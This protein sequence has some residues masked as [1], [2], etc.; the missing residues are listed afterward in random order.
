[1]QQFVVNTEDRK[2]SIK[3]IFLSVEDGDIILNP[4]YQRNYVYDTKRASKII[5]SLLLDIPLPAIFANE[6]QDGSMEI[7]DGVQRITSIIK[8]MRNEYPLLGLE[9]LSE[10][11]NKY[12]KDLSNDEKKFFRQSSLRIIKFKKDCSE[13]LKF[14]IFL[15]LNQGSVKLNNQE[16]RNCMYRGYFNDKLRELSNNKTVKE[17]LSFNENKINRFAIEEFILRGITFLNYNSIVNKKTLNHN[18]NYIMKTYRNS[19]DEVDKMTKDYLEVLS[20]I[21]TIL[22]N[23]A[24]KAEFNEKHK[25]IASYYDSFIIVF[26]KYKKQALIQN[27]DKIK[28]AIKSCFK[29]EEFLNT[30]K[31][32]TT[33]YKNILLRNDIIEKSIKEYI[34]ELDDKRLFSYEDKIKMF[35]NDNICA[36]CKNKIEDINDSNIDHIIPWSKGG[37]TILSNAQLTHEFCNK[38]KSNS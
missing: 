22:G 14:E 12:F 8:F 38:S 32:Q 6:E 1:M 37:K 18:M 25:F 7:I 34:I 20:T 31:L 2:S 4:E 16:L 21:K 15:R 9:I 10:L 30:M 26:K 33:N 17:L 13:D 27:K 36:I 5:E 19:K 11:N 35:D 28:E 29:K 3:E 23:N 24:F